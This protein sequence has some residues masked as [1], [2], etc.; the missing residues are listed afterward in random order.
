MEQSERS[1]FEITILMPCLNEVRTLAACIDE[2]KAAMERFDWDFEIVI[3]DNGSTDGS[4]DLARDCG[5]RVVVAFEKG[6]GNALRR[7]IQDA[8]GDFV[9]M[10]DCDGSYDFGE[11]STLITK[12]NEGFDVVIGNRFRGGILKDAMPWTHRYI[13][14]PFLS[15]VGHILFRGS[16]RDFHCGLRGF[17]RDVFEQLKLR[18]TGM[19]FA[20]EMVIRA[21]IVGLR[22]A[23]VPVSL[24]PDGRDR[25]PHLRRWRDGWRHLILLLQLAPQGS[26][27]RH[28]LGRMA[29][30]LTPRQNHYDGM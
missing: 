3:A 1:A 5:A 21:E 29:S 13:G 4:Q 23:E 17:R 6:Y 8:K 14:N 22:T 16:I 9:I 7:G 19:E 30:R 25:P 28:T 26:L 27:Y 18:S 2:A 10:A 20:S 24:R 15:G 12:L 11:A